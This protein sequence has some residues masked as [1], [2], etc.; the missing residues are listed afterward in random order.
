MWLLAVTNHASMPVAELLR[1]LEGSSA[2]PTH[3]CW[4]SW[5]EVARL[6]SNEQ[7]EE[8]RGWCEDLLEVLTRMG[9]AP[10]D[11]FGEALE[12]ASTQRMDL[13]W[14]KNPVLGGDIVG[15]PGFAEVLEIASSLHP[16]TLNALH[17][18]TPRAGDTV[19][20]SECIAQAQAYA[21]NGGER[22]LFKSG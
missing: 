14:V 4:I 11:G 13:P 6:L 12:A 5:L 3:V 16:L 7:T 10:F 9:L 22:W 19:G 2:D 18:S 8:C 21:E 17:P 1:Q 20:F 15:S